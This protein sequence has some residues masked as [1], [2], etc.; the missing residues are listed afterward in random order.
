[1][2]EAKI[3][4][5]P[6]E[7][8]DGLPLSWRMPANVNLVGQNDIVMTANVSDDTLPIED[9][10]EDPDLINFLKSHTLESDRASE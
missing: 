6:D 5:N 10:P 4:V 7:Y 1:M 9:I 8:S 3:I 2:I